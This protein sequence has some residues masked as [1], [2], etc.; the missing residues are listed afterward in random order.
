MF[1]LL[2]NYLFLFISAVFL[3]ACGEDSAPVE[4]VA[5]SS[6]PVVEEEIATQLPAEVPVVEP[7]EA[8]TEEVMEAVYLPSHVVYQEEIY[9]NWPYTKAS[10][11]TSVVE[12]TTT[13]PAKAF[14]H[15]QEVIYQDEIYANWPYN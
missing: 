3:M 10:S 5:V 2:K 14:M 8:V 9:K 12:E 7:E 4:K 15:D 6:T 11:A 1:R 13:A